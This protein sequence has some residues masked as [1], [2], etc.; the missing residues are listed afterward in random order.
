MMD[1]DEYKAQVAEFAKGAATEQLAQLARLRNF[2]I[3]AE[4]ETS[5]LT[6]TKEWDHFLARIQAA[7]D[8]VG[9]VRTMTAEQLISHTTVE[10]ATIRGLKT[11]LAWLDGMQ[12]ALQEVMALPKAIRENGETAR[13]ITLPEAVL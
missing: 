5:L 6:G 8:Q 3:E 12:W 7:K 11:K 2:A 1:Y 4:V 9:A 13:A 10:E